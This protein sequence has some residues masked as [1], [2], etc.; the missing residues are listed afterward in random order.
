MAATS[1]RGGG[2]AQTGH[3]RQVACEDEDEEW[4]RSIQ[5]FVFRA[6]PPPPPSRGTYRAIGHGVCVD[7]AG[8]QRL[9]I[10]GELAQR[11]IRRVVQARRGLLAG[12]GELCSIGVGGGVGL[13]RWRR[14]WRRLCLCLCL[15]MCFF[16]DSI[17]KVCGS[18]HSALTYDRRRRRRRRRLRQGSGVI[19]GVHKRAGLQL[20]ARARERERDISMNRTALCFF[21][22]FFSSLLPC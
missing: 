14:W 16:C 20:H 18:G 1:G 19:A 4:R 15:W 11:Q 21:F 2:A 6:P 3:V 8:A 12:K 10:A 9:R 17:S 22:F 7:S 13:E 5:L